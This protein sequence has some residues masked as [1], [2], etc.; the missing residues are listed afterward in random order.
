[1]NKRGVEFMTVIITIVLAI[2]VA[3]LVVFFTTDF[4]SFLTGITQT[5]DPGKEALRAEVCGSAFNEVD[6][7]R[8]S[9]VGEKKETVFINCEYGNAN[10]QASFENENGL[11]CDLNTDKTKCLELAGSDGQGNPDFKE[12][13]INGKICK[14]NEANVVTLD[15]VPISSS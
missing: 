1:M 9:D 13:S 5:V 3:L 4:F 10:F 6:Y 8:F 7:C 14:R 15:G 11:T 12:A 2:I